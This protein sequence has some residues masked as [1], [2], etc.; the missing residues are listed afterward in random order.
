MIVLVFDCETTNLLSDK[1]VDICRIVQLAWIV[2]DTK[3][4]KVEEN[5]FILN[6]HCKIDNSHIHGITTEISKNG[7]EFSD[8]VDIFLEDVRKCEMMVGH[9]LN[10]D[11]NSV[12]VELGRLNRF[13]DIDYL[14]SK[15]FY[16]TMKEACKKLKLE[17][18]PRLV[19]L[20]K[21]FFGFDFENAH[22]AIEDVKATLKCY[23]ELTKQR[24][25]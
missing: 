6:S 13:D 18:F 15:T 23:L 19:N 24:I 5:D 3:T 17:K 21:Y 22:D 4:K 9:N 25:N 20:Y 10:Y 7:Y 11:L 2:Y 14:Y 1:T 8:I 16:D 12:E